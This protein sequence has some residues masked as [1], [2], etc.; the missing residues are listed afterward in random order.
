MAC[1]ATLWL[2]QMLKVKSNY[3]FSLPFPVIFLAFPAQA[4]KIKTISGYGKAGLLGDFEGEI[5]FNNHYP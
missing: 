2:G 3:S 5:T 4:E 1:H